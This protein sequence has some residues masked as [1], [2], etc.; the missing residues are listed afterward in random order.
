MEL[1]L[2]L[3]VEHGLPVVHVMLRLPGVGVGVVVHGEVG[4]VGGGL[5]E[6]VQGGVGGG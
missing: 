5:V 1:L 3:H 6:L 2:L 4:D